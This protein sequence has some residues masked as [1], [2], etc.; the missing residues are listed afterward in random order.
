MSKIIIEV[1]IEKLKKAILSLPKDVFE[2]FIEDINN[3]NIY[4]T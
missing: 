4:R 1:D 3:M 2:K